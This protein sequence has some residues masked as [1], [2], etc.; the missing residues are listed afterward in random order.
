[1]E[2]KLVGGTRQI[3]AEAAASI[4]EVQ[5]ALNATPISTPVA[6]AG[7]DSSIQNSAVLRL[8]P[9]TFPQATTALPCS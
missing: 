7:A 5:V 3:G 2:P 8:T 6:D 4:I 1:V 9:P